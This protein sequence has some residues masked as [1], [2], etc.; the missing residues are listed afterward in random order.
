MKFL[1]FF[2]AG[3]LGGVLA[4]MG[5]GG[6]TLTIPLLVLALGVG[7]LTAQFVNLIA[8]LSSGSAALALHVKNGLVD[9]DNLSWLLVPALISAVIASVFALD[10]DDTLLRKLFGG[11]LIIVAAVSLSV[12]IFKKG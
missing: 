7:Q 11:F 5:M 12:K 10:L 2:L 3:T 9:A 1:W 8:F 6:G 4:G